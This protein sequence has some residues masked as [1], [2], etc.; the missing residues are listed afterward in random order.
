MSDRSQHCP[1]LAVR[2]F[3]HNQ[4]C[5]RQKS[6]FPGFGTGNSSPCGKN[7]TADE[8]SG[9][10]TV[11]LDLEV[12]PVCL[13]NWSFGSLKTKEM[14]NGNPVRSLTHSTQQI[15]EHTQHET[16]KIS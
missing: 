15:R 4:I 2:D 14:E 11:C 13:L 8:K 1:L 5:H 16:H 3:H 6:D 9:Y 7:L 10:F 12:I